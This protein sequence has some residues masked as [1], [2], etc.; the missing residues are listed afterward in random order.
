MHD[1]EAASM[2]GTQEPSVRLDLS[3]GAKQQNQHWVQDRV[4]GKMKWE[5]TQRHVVLAHELSHADKTIR[6]SGGSGWVKNP[7]NPYVKPGL[8]WMGEEKLNELETIGVPGFVR[9]GDITENDIRVDQGLNLRYS[10]EGKLPD[11]EK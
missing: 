5:A 11:A 6:D 8:E 4:T 1:P 10:H 2:Q 9:E 3:K 7:Y